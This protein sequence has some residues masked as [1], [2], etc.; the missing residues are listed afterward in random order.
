MISCGIGDIGIL[1][2]GLIAPGLP[3][4]PASLPILAGKTAYV[5]GH[6]LPPFNTSLLP[7]N[8]RRRLTT[9][10]KLALVVAE[11]TIKD[12]KIEPDMPSI[13]ASS[14]GD[15]EIVDQICTALLMPHRPVSPT[16]FHNSVHN[17][18]AGYWSIATRCQAPSLSISAGDA[19]FA[20]G[21]LE[22]AA[23][24]NM[25]NSPVLLVAYDQP[26]PEPIATA[27]PLAAPFAVALILGVHNDSDLAA[28][29]LRLDFAQQEQPME[30]AGLEQLRRGNPAARSL[31]LLQV[32]AEKTTAEKMSK[33][34]GGKAISL[35]YP[36]NRRLVVN[37]R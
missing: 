20:A 34:S 2:I 3:G 23:V 13:F 14:T 6:T 15:N 17:A 19:S 11:A 9:T 24:V 26:A 18:P 5:A 32:L 27:H 29:E 10:S 33:P 21:L 36:G 35:C 16:H 8:E 12:A 28:I 1:G 30:D 37:V 4:W 25:E 7:S 31:P 22:A